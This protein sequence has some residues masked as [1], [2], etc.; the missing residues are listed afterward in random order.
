ME[1]DPGRPEGE[2]LTQGSGKGLLCQAE[3]LL[4]KPTCAEWPT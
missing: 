4:S 2:E 3:R 1:A